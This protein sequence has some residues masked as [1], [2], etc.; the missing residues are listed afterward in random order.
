[1]STT[2]PAQSVEDLT[3]AAAAYPVQPHPAPLSDQERAAA[4]THPKFGTVFTDH[5]ARARWTIEAGWSQRRV[6]A[7]GPLQL[8][9][10]TAVLHYAQEVFEGLKAYRHADGSIWSFRPEAN[11]ARL[12]ASSRRLALPELSIADFM[13]SIVALVQVDR[14]W[15]PAEPDTSLYLRPFMY[16]SEKFIGVRPSAEVEYL[17]IASPA[18]PYFSGGV[19]PVSIW[20]AQEYHRS[21]P[22][23]T[24]TAKCGGN[25]AASLLPQK[26]AAEQG[27]DQVC[28]LDATTNALIEELGGMNIFAVY[29]DGRVVTPELS[30]TILEGITR[31]SIIRL[32]VDQGREVI[33]KPVPLAALQDDIASGAISEV[34]ACGTAAVVTPIGR[35]AGEGFDLTIADGEPGAVTTQIREHLT[36]IQYGRAPDPYGWMRRLV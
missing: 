17:V 22:G 19:Q 24:G 18:G 30:G 32:L 36:D 5:M 12:A 28:F 16:A 20:V 13:G 25:Y 14:D 11:G 35:L 15:V 29:E 2:T 26:I 33:E 9:P 10:A 3:A 6:E 4:T 1:M 21:G 34:F 23:G 31:S 27:F 8:D 7:Y